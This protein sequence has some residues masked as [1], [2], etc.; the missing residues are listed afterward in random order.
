MLI[1][2]KK[3]NWEEA[4]SRYRYDIG[5]TCENCLMHLPT[6][7]V[8]FQQ[9]LAPLSDACMVGAGV[10]E[11]GVRMRAEL[12]RADGT[13]VTMLGCLGFADR[14]G[15]DDDGL[16]GC[17]TKRSRVSRETT[18]L[19]DESTCENWLRISVSIFT[20]KRK[21]SEKLVPT[22]LH[23]DFPKRNSGYT[24]YGDRYQFDYQI[25]VPVSEA[26]QPTIKPGDRIRCIC[27]VHVRISLDTSS[28]HSYYTNRKPFD[29]HLDLIR[30]VRYSS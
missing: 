20:G 7:V 24:K 25:M 19:F 17:I 30:V 12:Y 27:E 13:F 21:V 9:K 3:G 10:H 18:D 26:R 6:A 1:D 5:R 23:S 16:T 8:P 14:F 28:T 29:L 4:T 15:S 2:V 22:F 11:V